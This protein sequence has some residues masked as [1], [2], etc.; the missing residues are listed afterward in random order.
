MPSGNVDV[1]R[2]VGR[3]G[4]I[5]FG[6]VLS[7]P[8]GRGGGPGIVPFPQRDEAPWPLDW[9][10]PAADSGEFARPDQPLRREAASPAGLL[11]PDRPL[12]RGRHSRR[13]E[14]AGDVHVVGETGGEGGRFGRGGRVDHRGDRQT[15]I[16]AGQRR[17]RLVDRPG[18]VRREDGGFGRQVASE[19][20]YSA[21]AVGRG[22][23]EN[24][25]GLGQQ[26]HD[27]VLTLAT[28]AMSRSTR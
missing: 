24:V 15:P 14:D 2:D 9:R 27:R 16:L 10:S 25:G 20:D 12:E 19:K 18:M 28:A 22:G 21:A 3:E 26:R 8:G 5:A 11:Q 6:V 13:L 1:E 7:T 4:D 23:G 17:E